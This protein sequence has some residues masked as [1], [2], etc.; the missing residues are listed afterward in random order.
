MKKTL[1]T[2]LACLSLALLLAMSAHG[3]E[4]GSAEVTASLLNF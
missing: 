1:R 4:I 2:M 3:L